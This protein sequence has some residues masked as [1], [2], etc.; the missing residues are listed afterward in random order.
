MARGIGDVE[1]W[2]AV[3]W[4]AGMGFSVMLVA[5][6]LWYRARSLR[7][8]PRQVATYRTVGREGSRRASDLRG[9]VTV[10]VGVGALS[11]LLYLGLYVE[12]VQWLFDAPESPRISGDLFFWVVLVNETCAAAALYAGWRDPYS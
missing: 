3:A 8:E 10:L 4:V 12:L 6:V 9:L 11:Q 2:R 5:G 1:G 7:D